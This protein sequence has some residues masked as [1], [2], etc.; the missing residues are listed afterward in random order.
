MAKLDVAQLAG[1]GLLR[2]AH[3][4][5][6]D[7]AAHVLETD[8]RGHQGL[9]ALGA[10]GEHELAQHLVLDEGK[11]LVVALVLIVVAVDVDDQHAVQIALIRLAPRVGEQPG[12]VQLLNR[13]PSTAIGDEI[14]GVSP[15]VSNPFSASR[16]V[17]AP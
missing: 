5:T 11:K 9:A 10:A 12:C 4:I 13:N 15:A 7:A 2:S 14:H 3:R 6:G 1:I 16:R 8:L 17:S